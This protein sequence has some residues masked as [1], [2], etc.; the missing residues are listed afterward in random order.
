[1][2]GSAR[3]QVFQIV[4]REGSVSN[5]ALVLGCSQPT[6]SHHLAA[7]EQELETP[8][9]IRHSRGVELTSAGQVLLTAADR[10]LAQ[11][12][13]AE[14]S[15]RAHA[16]LD[17]GTLRVGTFAT[18]ASTLLPLV[19]RRFDRLHPGVTVTLS[20]YTLPEDSV[21]DVR[22]DGLD[23][24]LIFHA[25]G[26]SPDLPGVRL[27]WLFDDPLCVAVPSA[28]PSPST[29]KVP[30]ENFRDQPWITQR[31]ERDPCHL[32]L[33]E[34]SER[35]GFKPNITIRSDDYMTVTQMVADGFGVALVPKLS[36]HHM[37]EGTRLVPV[38]DP[39]VHRQ[40]SAVS[41]VGASSGAAQIF[42]QVL[43]EATQSL[44]ASSPDSAA[45]H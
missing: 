21:R 29:A 25:P 33:L 5:A 42:L 15:V 1:M 37:A 20:E 32:V 11:I 19:L 43:R 18:A 12:E 31:S 41:R 17:T 40:V 22:A 23:V 24:G 27:T 2:I 13:A 9:L 16:R 4:A 8:L 26:H 36:E 38:S 7:L 6:V 30:I 44:A 39:A 10:I 28:H 35:A 34:A 14:E 3:L 45:S